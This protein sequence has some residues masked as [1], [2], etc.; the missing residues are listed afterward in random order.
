MK[1]VELFGCIRLQRCA[2]WQD[3]RVSISVNAQMPVRE[4]LELQPANPKVSVG[5]VDLQ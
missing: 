4:K 5:A 2:C 3:M 1:S